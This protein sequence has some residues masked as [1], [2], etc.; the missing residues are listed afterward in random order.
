MKGVIGTPELVS[1]LVAMAGVIGYILRTLFAAN[2]SE[3][4]QIMKAYLDHV[5]AA[6]RSQERT[7]EAITQLANAVSENTSTLRRHSDYTQAEHKALLDA[8]RKEE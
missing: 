6:T 8:L 1:A 5:S 4:S 2:Q 3:K 7:A